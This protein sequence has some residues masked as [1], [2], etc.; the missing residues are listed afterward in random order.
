[1]IVGCLR[2]DKFAVVGTIP[3]VRAAGLKEGA[4]QGAKRL[5][6]LAGVTA[7]KC[8]AGK[9][10]EQLLKR[11]VRLRRVASTRISGVGCQWPP[12]AYAKR[13]KTIGLLIKSTLDSQIESRE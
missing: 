5:D 4:C 12:I 1:M 6:K 9:I 10:E 2:S 3:E 7:L 8:G 13:L 11:L